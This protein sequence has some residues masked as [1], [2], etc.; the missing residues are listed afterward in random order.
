MAITGKFRASFSRK[1]KICFA[2]FVWPLKLSKIIR[3]I[4]M[5]A[6]NGAHVLF[7]KSEKYWTDF[8][9]ELLLKLILYCIIYIIKN[10]VV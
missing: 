5:R 2:S 4:N 10:Y 7:A 8:V 9:I 6:K 3:F 1:A